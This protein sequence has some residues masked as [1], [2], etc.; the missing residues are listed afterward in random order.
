MTTETV[1]YILFSTLGVLAILFCVTIVFVTKDDYKRRQHT[2][3]IKADIRK[4]QKK[5]QNKRNKLDKIKGKYRKKSK[6]IH[7]GG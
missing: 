3:E 1:A 7:F 4:Y 2:E 5:R 6:Y